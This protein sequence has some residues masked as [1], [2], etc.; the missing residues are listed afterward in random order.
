MISSFCLIYCL[1]FC[2]IYCLRFW[3]NLKH[4]PTDNAKSY[5][6]PLLVVCDY[7]GTGLIY[8]HCVP[9]CWKCH[10]SDPNCVADDVAIRSDCEAGCACPRGM[11][12]DGRKC[13]MAQDC[14]C[15]LDIPSEQNNK[16]VLLVS[17]MSE[18]GKLVM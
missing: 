11:L 12:F 16:L 17:L 4:L 1:R 3:A 6:S 10:V 14:P 2:L 18:L 8:T 9:K 7:P 15:V 13:V 5:I